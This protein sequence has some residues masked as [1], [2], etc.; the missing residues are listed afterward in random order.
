MTYRK[1]NVVMLGFDNGIRI[2]RAVDRFFDE[3][4]FSGLDVDFYLIAVGYPL[5]TPLL[6]SMELEMIARDNSINLVVMDN[7]GQDGNLLKAHELLGSDAPMICYD[8]DT[9][10]NKPSWLKDALD[11]MDADPHCGFVTINCSRTDNA[12][13]QQTEHSMVAG[14]QVAKLRWP[15]GWPMLLFSSRFPWHQ[16]RKSHSFYGGTEGNIL[17][18]LKA[19]YMH[20]YMLRQ[21]DDLQ[22]TEDRD[23][24]YTAWK[25]YAIVRPDAK[26][27]ADWLKDQ[28]TA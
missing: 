19:E 10:P 1:V 28:H 23:A 7:L 27:L 3:T 8:A 22:D 9:R 17:N 5:P 11:V 26:S 14:V 21:H 24:E 6:N 12:L 15:G 16:M 13:C 18:A 4:D 2:G 25:H 20:G